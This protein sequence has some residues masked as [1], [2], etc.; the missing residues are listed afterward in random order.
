MRRQIFY[1]L[2]HNPMEAD[3]VPSLSADLVEAP[4]WRLPSTATT[5]RWPSGV[6][7]TRSVTPSP[8]PTRFIASHV[9]VL[10][11]LEAIRRLQLGLGN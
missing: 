10:Q 7:A 9:K 3:L 1:F 6:M 11:E 5:A 8:H 4:V 2:Q